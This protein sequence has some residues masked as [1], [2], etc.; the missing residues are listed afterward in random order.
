MTPW[1]MTAVACATLVLLPACAR[2]PVQVAWDDTYAAAAYPPSSD[3]DVSMRFGTTGD[4]THGHRSDR[5]GEPSRPNRMS[6]AVAR[7]DVS[8]DPDRLLELARSAPRP[9]DAGAARLEAAHLLRREGDHLAAARIYRELADHSIRKPERARAH[10]ELGRL[11]EEHGQ[12]DTARTIY[13]LLVAHYPDLMPGERALSHLLRMALVDGDAAVDE[14]L[15]WTH[16]LFP[17]LEHTSLGDNLVIQVADEAKRRAERDDA[18]AQTTSP[19]SPYWAQ[20]EAWYRRVTKDFPD[21]GM[22]NDAWWELSKIFHRQ[23]RFPEE[24]DAIT[25]IIATRAQISLFGQ[26]EHPYFY[27]GLQRIARIQL[28]DLDDPRTAAQTYLS[29]AERYP[30]SILRDDVRFFALCARLRAGLDAEPLRQLLVE[31]HPDSK[32]H[33]RLD[34]AFADPRGPHCVPRVVE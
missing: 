30:L 20:A 4:E 28:V 24:I 21:S 11:A 9:T 29:Y 3:P 15:A 14:H 13:R 8:P 12:R 5:S 32:Y 25:R 19:T 2:N 34:A 33:R 22:W 7:A 10:Y 27:L 6:G 18:A 26:D 31:E 17:V 1:P 16:S 23:G